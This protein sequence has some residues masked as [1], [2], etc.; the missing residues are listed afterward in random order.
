MLPRNNASAPRSPTR[1]MSGRN[2]GSLNV[3]PTSNGERNTNRPRPKDRSLFVFRS[4]LLVR[5][6]FVDPSFAPDPARIG[7]R[8][9]FAL[10]LGSI[11]PPA[12]LLAT[13]ELGPGEDANCGGRYAK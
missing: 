9:A 2:D 8:A 10:A 5:G 7:L 3:P 12:A 6:T 11:A 4:P 13:L 1:F